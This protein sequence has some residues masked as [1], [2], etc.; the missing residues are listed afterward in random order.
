[1]VQN[2]L[3]GASFC[4]VG[5]FRGTRKLHPVTQPGNLQVHISTNVHNFSFLTFSLKMIQKPQ[6]SH[7]NAANLTFPRILQSYPQENWSNAK[8]KKTKK[9]MTLLLESESNGPDSRFL[10]RSWPEDSEILSCWPFTSP[11]FSPNIS[12][13]W[14]P[15]PD[16]LQLLNREAGF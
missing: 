10:G 1:M 13:F 11:S 7:G 14:D 4:L 16:F 2:P 12:G 15:L 9:Y 5:P 6:L 8:K 3:A